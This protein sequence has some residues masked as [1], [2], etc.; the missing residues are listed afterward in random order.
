M[1]S[2]WIFVKIVIVSVMCCLVN[3][4]VPSLLWISEARQPVKNIYLDFDTTLT[5]DEFSE[6]VRNAFCRT[7][8]YPDCDCGDICND[9]MVR[10]SN[11]C[12]INFC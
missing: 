5:T 2:S 9:T 7:V 1:K 12:L 11:L 4:S 6:V 8:K 10:T 3:G